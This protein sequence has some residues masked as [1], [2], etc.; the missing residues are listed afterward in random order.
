MKRRTLLALTG[1]VALL[2]GSITFGA[3]IDE[4]KWFHLLAMAFIFIGGYA[5]AVSDNR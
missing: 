5:L 2:S 3:T 4:L 1:N